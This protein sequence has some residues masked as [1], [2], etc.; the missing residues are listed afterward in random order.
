[1]SSRASKKAEIRLAKDMHGRPVPASGA[2]AGL[3][4]DVITERFLVE[5]KGTGARQYPL[6]ADLLRKIQL[7]ALSRGRDPL[8]VVE[9]SPSERFVVMPLPQFLEIIDEA[10]R[11]SDDSVRETNIRSARPPARSLFGRNLARA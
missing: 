1:M 5:H 10:E 2:I 7:E 4:G 9:F 11:K 6:K 3:P 8:F